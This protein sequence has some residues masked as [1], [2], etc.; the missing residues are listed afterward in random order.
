MPSSSAPGTD[1]RRGSAPVASSSRSYPN[2]SPVESAT[3]RAAVSIASTAVE[4]RRSMA[5]AA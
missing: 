3:S 5:F 2:R 1:S 4:V